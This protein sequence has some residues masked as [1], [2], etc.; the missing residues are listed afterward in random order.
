MFLGA[1]AGLMAGLLGIGGG[2]IIVP[3]LVFL[4]PIFQS[5][6]PEQVMVVAIASSLCSIIFT[7]SS[8]AWAHHQLHHISWNYTPALLIGAAIGAAITGYLAHLIDANILKKIFGCAVLFLGLRM[9]INPVSIHRRP[10]PA[11]PVLSLFSVG[12]STLASLLGIGGGALYV[13]MLTHFSV[14]VRHAIGA[15]SIVGFVI[16]C[17]ATS[18]Y[19]ISGW[20]Q[21]ED[22]VG[23][24]GYVYWPAVVGIVSTSL[25]A[26]QYGA[27]LTSY[28]PVEKIKKIFGIFLLIVSA[29]MLLS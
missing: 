1:F 8:S 29:R 28:L 26:A 18:G 11:N 27:K 23:Y 5:L 14:G 20:K 12:L 21:F 19:V 4:L 15:A 2:L 3:V 16:A 17:F 13:P 22:K 24:L 10:L 9:L 7:C 6:P 25:I